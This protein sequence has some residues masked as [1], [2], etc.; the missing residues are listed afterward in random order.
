ALVCCLVTT[1]AFG[2]VPAWFAA[3]TDPNEKLKESVRSATGSRSQHRFQHFLIIGEVALA[4]MLL[5]GA[6]TTIRLLQ[7]FSALQPGWRVDGLLTAQVSL[8]RAKYSSPER[9]NAFCAQLEERLASLPG[10]QGAAFTDDL[11]TAAFWN[12]RPL[13][14]EDGAAPRPNE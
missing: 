6:G 13:R 9:R 2:T 12:T 1:V 11:P 5:T 10:V 8:P 3:R 14:I 7:R 4:L